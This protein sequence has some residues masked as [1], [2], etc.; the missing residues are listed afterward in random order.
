M[1]APRN[2]YGVQGMFHKRKRIILTLMWLNKGTRT[3][4]GS[5]GRLN[6]SRSL[7]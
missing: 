6:N 4:I 2:A 1:K 5:T 3:D 7:F